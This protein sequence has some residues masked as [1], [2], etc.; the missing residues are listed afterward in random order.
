MKRKHIL[1]R[2]VADKLKEDIMSGRY[3]IGSFLPTETELEATF[4]VSKITVRK[5]I[6]LLAVDEYVEKR[7]GRGTTV[8]SNRPYNKLSKGTTFS[9]LLEKTGKEYTKKNLSYELV[10][11][12]P[13][14]PAYSLMGKEVMRLRRMYYFDHQ[15]FIYYEYH[16]P[17]QLK[18]TSI[19]VFE[20]KSLYRLLDEHRMI[21][22]RFQDAFVATT[23]TEE[24]QK[25]MITPEVAALKRTRYS[26][27][28][29]GEVVEYTEGIYNTA[30]H[31]YMIE[32]EA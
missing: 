28:L 4:N 13:E 11:L 3:P 2:D 8:L 32:F 12:A 26:Y 24:Q 30:L 1:Y 16:L 7:S 20:E 17:K 25:F 23:L 10:E 5:A 6:E 31:P 15:P 27:D 22:D 29:Q 19:E 18:G 21:I 14:H 9:Q